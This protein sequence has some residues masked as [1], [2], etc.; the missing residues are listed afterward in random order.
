MLPFRMVAACLYALLVSGCTHLNLEDCPDRVLGNDTRARLRTSHYRVQLADEGLAASRF[1]PYA[2]MSAYA[3]RDGAKCTPNANDK[4]IGDAEQQQLLTALAATTPEDSRWTLV[5]ELESADGRK[6]QLGLAGDCEDELGMMFHVWQRQQGDQTFVTI[7]FRGT[8]RANDWLYGNLWWLVRFLPMDNQ[9]ER[10][11]KHAKEILAAYQQRELTLHH[12]RPVVTSTGH[13]LGGSLAQ[14]IL[15][16]NPKDVS[17]AIAFDPSSV[18]GFAA[19]GKANQ[20]EGCACLGELGP[21]ARIIRVYQSYE[22]LA[23]LRIFHKIFFPP[24]RHVQ[25]VR[26]PFATSWNPIAKHSMKEFALNLAA[27]AHHQ[28]IF[29]PGRQW[30]ASDNA[31]CTNKL[32]EKQKNSCAINSENGRA[33]PQ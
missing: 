30:Y 16:S 25:E 10:A 24:E 20:H 31:L 28:P 2:I 17:Q 5:R 6:L 3:Y 29:D 21:E 12:P 32:V 8:S 1:L 18:T 33:C 9:L 19:A 7:A 11:Q 22:V 15:Y 14:F 27:T 26:F 23:N 13:S 4:R